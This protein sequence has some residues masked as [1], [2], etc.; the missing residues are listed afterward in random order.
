MYIDKAADYSTDGFLV[1]FRRFLSLRGCPEK[2]YSDCG[3]QLVAAD[4]ELR[5]VVKNL[6]Q[7]SLF[8]FGANKEI[9]CF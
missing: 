5:D 7:T 1:T 8:G 6:D 4:E 2:L 3:S 9:E